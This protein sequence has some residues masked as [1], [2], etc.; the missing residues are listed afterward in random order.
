M[1]TEKERQPGWYWI[2]PNHQDKWLA[3]EYM[4]EGATFSCDDG[5]FTYHSCTIGPRIP[6]P[7]E[8]EYGVVDRASVFSRAAHAAV[9]QVRKYTGEPYWHH[10]R[11]VAAMIRRHGGT[12]D[13]IAASFLHD[14][15]EDTEV[16]HRQV[17]DE[18][19]D[20]VAALVFD[21]TDQYDDPSTG[22]RAKRKSLERQRLAGV[23]PEAATI[24]Y[25][26][27]IDNT[28]SIAQHDPGFSKVY[29]GE[30]RELLQVMTQG[31]Q[32]LWNETWGAMTKAEEMLRA[33]ELNND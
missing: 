27:L 5:V 24:K 28:Q 13:M 2:K 11:A 10:T 15:V 31:N 7:S 12:P 22:N 17:A 23:S 16:K 33:K 21:L 3:A 9:G 4:E 25:A 26:D 20:Q 1:A 8:P 19:G 6:T 18:F 14:A 29:L 30:I 32:A